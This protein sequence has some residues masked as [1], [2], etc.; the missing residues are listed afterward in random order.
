[1]GAKIIDNTTYEVRTDGTKFEVVGPGI[2]FEWRTF[3]DPAHIFDNE[4][5][6]SKVAYI[7]NEAYL[8]GKRAAKEEIRELLG[9][10]KA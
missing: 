1:M 3:D 5:I 8:A 2:C 7:A 4:L 10:K 6:A 9:A